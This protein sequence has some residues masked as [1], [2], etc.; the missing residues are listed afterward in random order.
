MKLLR[1]RA[2]KL[3]A[4]VLCMIMALS[5]LSSGALA[6]DDKAESKEKVKIMFSGNALSPNPQ[7]IPY[8][9]LIGEYMGERLSKSA[10]IITSDIVDVDEPDFLKKV[11][12]Q[13][14]GENPDIVFFEV[15]ISKR[16]KGTEKD[17]LSKFEA[18]VKALDKC[19]NPPAVY[20]MYVP[21]SSFYDFRKPFDKIAEY[22]NINVIDV[23]KILKEK[24]INKK[25]ETS[26][27][28]TAGLIP[29]EEGHKII[30]EMAEKLLKGIK[31]LEK[32]AALEKEPLTDISKYSAEDNGGSGESPETPEIGEENV[33]YVS[34][35]GGDSASGTINSPLRSLEGARN[36]IRNLKKVQG[37]KFSGAKVYLREGTYVLEKGFELYAEDSGTENAPITYS[38]YPGEEVRIT[39]GK[40]LD[41]S[42]FRLVTEKDILERIPEAAR[43]KVYSYNLFSN[44]INPGVYRLGDQLK[45][46]PSMDIY[47]VGNILIANERQEQRA[48]YPNGGYSLLSSRQTSN[49]TELYYDDEVGDRWKTADNAW[50]RGM[51]GQM[52]YRE[53]IKP[54]KIDFEN[55]IIYLSQGVSSGPT[56][57]FSWSIVNLLEELDIPGEWYADENKG[58]LYYYPREDIK[59]S[60]IIFSSNIKPIFT[61]NETK[62]V[63]IEN[64]RFVC[65][66]DTAIR[67]NDGY[68][69]TVYSCEVKNMGYYGI[70]VYNTGTKGAGYNVIKDNFVSYTGR[71]GINFEG[72]NRREQI[73]QGDVAENNFLEYYATE[74][75]SNTGAITTDG[76]VGVAI[77]NNTIHDDDSC[78]IWM[79]GNDDIIEYNEIYNVVKGV[80]DY[81]A[82]Y[83][84]EKGAT[85]QGVRVNHNYLHDVTYTATAGTTGF[86]AGFY[87]DA[88]RNNGAKVDNNVFINVE[89]PIFFSNNHNMQA[90]GNLMLDTKDHSIRMWRSP[91]SD[92]VLEQQHQILAEQMADGTFYKAKNEVEAFN[93][94]L[95]RAI[96][97]EPDYNKE[98]QKNYW[99]KY[100][101]LEHYLTSNPLEARY[102]VVNN[103]AVFNSEKSDMLL[104]N[105]VAE[106]FETNDNYLTADTVKMPEGKTSQY[107]RIDAAM[108]IAAEKL[109]GFEV[110]NAREAGYNAEPKEIADFEIF[111]PVNDSTE[112]DAENVILRWDYSS[113]ADSYHVQVAADRDF[114]NVLFD[115]TVNDNFA[116]VSGIENGAKRYFWRVTASPLSEKFTK[117]K[118][119]KNGIFTF[120]TLKHKAADKSELEKDIEYSENVLSEM[121]E[122]NEGGEYPEGTRAALETEIAAAKAAIKNTR[123]EQRDIDE[124]ESS[125]YSVTQKLRSRVKLK[126]TDISEIISKPEDLT[127]AETAS[128]KTINGAE[129]SYIVAEGNS[130]TVK[131]DVAAYSEKKVQPGEVVRFTAKFGYNGVDAPSLYTVIGLRFNQTPIHVYRTSGYAFLAT[132]SNVELQAWK[133]PGGVGKMYFTKPNE[134]ITEDKEHDVEFGALP[135]DDGKAVRIILRIDGKVVYDETDSV[136]ILTEAG[137]LVISPSNPGASLTVSPAGKSFDYPSLVE[138][139]ADENSE[140]GK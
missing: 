28:L 36:R 90:K 41:G 135:A 59:T 100:P 4:L 70:H 124:A 103:N 77:R 115:K 78:A 19:E 69:N 54:K 95:Y 8:S 98:T 67:I 82:M 17:V 55:K 45:Y 43:G 117:E 13:I 39:N 109:D 6:M 51:F 60:E 47:G 44:G 62:Y 65:G 93:A 56:A 138:E 5:S 49:S 71:A 30:S 24:Y 72:G 38:A 102:I 80:D 108:K 114:K 76:T 120:T 84:S 96:L 16:H 137:S 83:G 18:A 89:C 105:S 129:S 29:G 35:N 33:I 12:E 125:L 106:Y 119:N 134:W 116:K 20:F 68:K 3:A 107:D 99:L 140:L 31:D 22:Y 37:E 128:G 81:G 64:M 61:L 73:D 88:N 87:S 79:A 94:L 101:W 132:K 53:T 139:L 50:I 26:D 40:I 1:K 25:L 122:G 126:E 74:F 52:Y 131:D 127:V 112:L 104:P 14:V 136:N 46:H 118:H 34:L 58:V 63:N 11:N 7:V 57:G 27:F 10:E 97:Y 123:A 85:R 113:G 111:A 15:N 66:C 75:L 42:K 133:V 92:A 21:E 23:F 110:W 48:V 130:I 32:P 121:K 2:M 9:K 91:Y 86:L